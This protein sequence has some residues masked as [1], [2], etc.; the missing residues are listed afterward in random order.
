MVRHLITVSILALGLTAAA[1]A[2]AYADCEADLVQ[3]E[4][5]M[6]A[7]GQTPEHLAL[8][9]T[10]GEKASESLRKD[11]DKGCNQV[12]MDALKAVATQ[13]APAAAAPA[14]S[15]ASLGD[16]K[17]MRG[18]ADDTLKLA[19]KG[20]LAGAKTRIKDL[21]TAWDKARADMRSK[22]QSAWESLDKLIDAALKQLRADKPDAKTS[23]DTLNALLA[24]IDKTK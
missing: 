17:P 20:D 12:V 22:N 18:V 5:A 11:D 21:E 10:A 16:L 19:Q 24:Q 15:S 14:V 7:P 1:S 6:K 13:A 2:S 3:L 23:A 4:T 8:M 9:K